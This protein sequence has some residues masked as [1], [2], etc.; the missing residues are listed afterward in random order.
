MTKTINCKFNFWH[1]IDFDRVFQANRNKVIGLH[2]NNDIK[3]LY[4]LL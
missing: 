1:K 2:K 4:N 3:I